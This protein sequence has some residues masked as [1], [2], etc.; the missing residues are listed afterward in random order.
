MNSFFRPFKP[1]GLLPVALAIAIPLVGCSRTKK[2]VQDMPSS[3][4]YNPGYGPFDQNGN[5]VEAWA[6]KPARQH[7]WNRKPIPPGPVSRTIARKDP[8]PLNLRE[9]P[10]VKRVSPLIAKAPPKPVPAKPAPAPVKP[11]P[12][13]VKPA[14]A[15][16]KPTPPPAP[17]PAAQHT[18]VK[19]DT[20]YSLGRRYGTSVGAIQR[21]NG[22]TG[23]L[24]RIG[25][26][27][28]IPR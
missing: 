10:P 17:K 9:Q 22:I 24:I 15:P 21:A 7:N 19:G 3:A 11:A 8:S 27:L 20:L 16:A 23:T 12:A 6:D 5:Y 4:S 13:P 25:Q 1:L 14:P 26:T 18:V 28:K 2:V